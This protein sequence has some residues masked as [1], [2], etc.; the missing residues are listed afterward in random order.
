MEKGKESDPRPFLDRAF[1]HDSLEKG[2]VGGT[3]RSNAGLD[4]LHRFMYP[5]PRLIYQR[6]NNRSFCYPSR[7]MQIRC[8]RGARSQSSIEARVCPVV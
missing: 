3:A 4:S 5:C 7:G 2:V 1:I 6:F 8:V